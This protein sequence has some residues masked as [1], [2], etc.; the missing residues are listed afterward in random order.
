MP[1]TTCCPRPGGDACPLH[2]GRSLVPDVEYPRSRGVLAVS[3]RLWRSDLRGF[4]G[5]G[6]WRCNRRNLSSSGGGS[7]RL[8]ARA[9]RARRPPRRRRPRRARFRFRAGLERRPPGSFRP[10]RRPRRRR[11][12]RRRTIGLGRRICMGSG[13]DCPPSAGRLPPP[14]QAL[15]ARIAELNTKAA[16]SETRRRVSIGGLPKDPGWRALPLQRGY[17]LRAAE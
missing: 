9:R 10:R 8:L 14:A 7:Q 5:A 13:R 1:G 3:P 16:R 2:A 17:E 12:L 15:R 11:T 4:A 6:R